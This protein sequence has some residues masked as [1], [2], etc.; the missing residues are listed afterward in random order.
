MW[1]WNPGPVNANNSRLTPAQ[2]ETGACARLQERRTVYG[3]N[4]IPTK[5]SPSFLQLCWDAAHDETL[6]M[7]FVSLHPH[8]AV[9]R[10]L[11]KKET[12]SQG[13]GGGSSC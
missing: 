4:E 9:L 8:A 3:K 7:L 2:L 11:T 5:E 10:G 12:G 1:A 13:M 6:I